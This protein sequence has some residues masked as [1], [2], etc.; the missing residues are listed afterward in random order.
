MAPFVII[1]AFILVILTLKGS[2]V[3][4]NRFVYD[5]IT[6]GGYGPGTYYP[7]IYL[8]MAI[9][10]PL[11][12][13][14][15]EKLNNG[16]SF[17][18]FFIISECLEIFCSL[19]SIP[20]TLYRLLCFRYVFLIYLG[21]I[22]AKE[23]IKFNG[24][25]VVLSIV[26]LCSL[27]FFAYGNIVAEPFFFTT[28]WNT[29]RWPCYYWVSCLFTGLVYGLYKLIRNNLYFTQLASKLSLASY[30][31]FLVQ[32]AFYSLLS[33]KE[34]YFINNE[35]VQF[36]LWYALAFLISIVGGIGLYKIE[37]KYI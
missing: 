27:M 6:G 12:R 3:E 17:I 15:C 11:M 21:W 22:W 16:K 35:N 24:L 1:E 36:A 7:W 31:I 28:G 32:M 5:G 34:I 37:K 10:I 4:F 33:P 25:T 2:F 9:L 8:Q 29:H 13:P 19:I 20:D 18:V 23:G 30:E 14:I 26:S